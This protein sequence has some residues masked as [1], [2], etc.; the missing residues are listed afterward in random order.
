MM[1]IARL[2]AYDEFV[3]FITSNPTVIQVAEFHLSDETQARIRF[4]LDV[5]RNDK[6][7]EADAEELDEYVR[8]EYIIQKAKVR[9]YE[10]LA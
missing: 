6:L 4:L 1:A 5:N 8:L 10:K 3:E 2:K 9:A 7:T